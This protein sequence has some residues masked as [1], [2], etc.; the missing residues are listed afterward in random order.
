MRSWHFVGIC[1]IGMSA[2]AQFAAAM[3]I[4]V[5]GSDRALDN[6]ENAALKSMLEAQG[7]TLYPQDGSRFDSGE[8]AV[9]AVVYST[10]I[11]ESNPDFARSSNIERIHR[12]TALKMLIKER[13]CED[14]LSIAVAGSCGKTSTT[15]L[16]AEAL[17][18][19]D[20]AAE[21]VN[22]GMIKAF[23]QGNYPGNYHPGDGALVFEADESDK[24]LLEFH[25][26]Y[27]LV[28]NIGTDHY[29]K[30]ELCSMFAQFVNQCSKGAVLQDEVYALIKEKIKPGLEIRTFGSSADADMV[31]HDYKSERG[32]SFADFGSGYFQLPSPGRHTAMN[33]AATVLLL[34]ILNYPR[35]NALTAALKT[36]GV[37]RRFDFKGRTANGA[38][39]YDD[40]A[41]NPEKV[42][43][44]LAA[45][46]ELEL[47]VMVD[48][49][50]W[51]AVG[52]AGQGS[53]WER[54]A[55]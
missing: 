40:Y 4:K 6:P 19:L 35:S 54:F 52:L 55:F 8:P 11:E 9:D 38:A 48:W 20:C 53:Q 15:A 5:S 43:N 18:N 47:A 3:Q 25:P 42:A 46:Q 7:I 44:I 13:C 33:V 30:A 34:E 17:N 14:K 37:A 2:L 22:G 45:A 41:H 27:A 51:Q 23:A 32:A 28:L 16:I 39:I 10:A 50:V 29:P 26:D 1:G 24:S 21:C 31:L 49:A 36:Q 12:A